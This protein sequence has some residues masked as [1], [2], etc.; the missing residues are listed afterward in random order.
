METRWGQAS[1][2]VGGRLRPALVLVHDSA[3]PD[4]QSDDIVLPASR[5]DVVRRTDGRAKCF[6]RHR[7]AMAAFGDDTRRI[8]YLCVGG[9]APPG[10]VFFAVGTENFAQVD[11]IGQ[12]SSQTYGG[13]MRFQFTQRQDVTGFAAYQKRT[14]DRTQTSLGFT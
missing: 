9:A 14:Q 1:A 2:R 11:Q 12:F 4:H 3:D 5:L 7:S 6:F 10:N 13:G 8:S